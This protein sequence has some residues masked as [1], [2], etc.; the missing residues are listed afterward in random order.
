M[1]VNIIAVFFLLFPYLYTSIAYGEDSPPKETRRLA[2]FIANQN[3]EVDPLV[4]PIN[5]AMKVANALKKANFTSLV[6]KDVPSK[7]QMEKVFDDFKGQINDG[8]TVLFYYAGHGSQ[9]EGNSQ[10]Y[11]TQDE[12]GMDAQQLIMDVLRD[13][14]KDGI[15]IIILDTCRPI[16]GKSEE[17]Q[18]D[19][20]RVGGGNA[21][22]VF[23]TKAGENAKDVAEKCD[24]KNSPFACDLIEGIERYHWQ[25]FEDVLQEVGKAVNTNTKGEQQVYVYGWVGKEFC[26]SN[27]LGTQNI[28]FA[29]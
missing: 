24:K 10:L 17:L 19:L 15:N 1:K 27:C 18:G 2:L 7:A 20:V 4:T 26:L 21:M 28:S 22:V 12:E 8:D 14:N 16:D 6:Y 3:Y 23:S 13:K 25:P 29:Q 9:K 5:D 11:A